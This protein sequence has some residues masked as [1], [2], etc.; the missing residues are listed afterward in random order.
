MALERRRRE[1]GPRG[2]AGRPRSPPCAVPPKRLE[3]RHDAFVAACCSPFVETRCLASGAFDILVP[4]GEHVFAASRY[5]R[6]LFRVEK[7]TGSLTEIAT[8]ERR[9][10][11][12]MVACAAGLYWLEDD[13]TS[14]RAIRFLPWTPGASVVCINEGRIDRHLACTTRHVWGSTGSCLWSLPHGADPAGKTFLPARDREDEPP[15]V[16]VGLAADGDVVVLL[17]QGSTA[18]TEIHCLREPATTWRRVG[19]ARQR[20]GGLSLSGGVLAWLAVE[21]G[22]SLAARLELGARGPIRR[23]KLRRS[24][25]FIG[26]G[27][28]G[29]VLVACDA[30][31][32]GVLDSLP[33]DG[34]KSVRRWQGARIEALAV[35]TDGIYLVADDRLLM[36]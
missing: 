11:E 8:I 17:R 23:R 20:H 7:R 28:D 36:L 29:S 26:V 31:E 5:Y 6:E 13:V 2:P 35:D 27:P 9:N 33:R 30:D 4:F 1:R 22:Q 14:E 15:K 24:P 12:S 10:V 3:G 19:R 18:D 16:T 34:S 25:R 32:G 21:D